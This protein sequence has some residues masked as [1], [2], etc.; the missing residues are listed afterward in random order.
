MA[1]DTKKVTVHLP[2][3]ELERAIRLTGK[4][5]TATLVQ[6]LREIDRRARRSSLRALK[7]KVRF[8]LDLEE[9]RR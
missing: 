4:G 2:V 9:T 3:E 8:Q 5:I 1:A 6:G 7:G